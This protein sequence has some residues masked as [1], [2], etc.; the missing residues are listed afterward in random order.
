MCININKKSVNI[1]YVDWLCLIG[2][3]IINIL[4]WYMIYPVW[5]YNNLTLNIALSL[6]FIYGIGLILFLGYDFNKIGLNIKSL[7]QALVVITAVHLFFV[8]FG[9]LLIKLGINLNLLK[10]SYQI[11]AVL[12]NWILTGL[13]EEL[14]FAGVIF[15]I[16]NKK[17][18]LKKKYLI[19][20]I[21]AFI[22]ALFHLPG[23]IAIGL[24]QGHI[25]LNIVMKL[26][27]NFVS[28]IV[29]GT[30][31]YFSRNLW[32]TAFAHGSTDYAL[33]PMITRTPIM[34]LLFMIT[35]IICGYYLGKKH[36]HNIKNIF[37]T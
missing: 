7:G 1:K 17:I 20:L 2:P 22:F 3:L 32:L 11:R 33:L 35:L 30:I 28:W 14:V 15:N 5:G 12:N 4:I 23:Y 6:N 37:S 18:T 26:L 9:Y 34:G 16:L 21:V 8:I 27:L 13:G 29:F 10:N 31:Y 25:G 24:S 19:V 36:K